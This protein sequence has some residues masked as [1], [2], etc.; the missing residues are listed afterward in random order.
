MAFEASQSPIQGDAMPPSYSAVADEHSGIDI[1]ETI[2][3]T[4][5]RELKSP[6]GESSPD[7]VRRLHNFLLY[8][9]AVDYM[10]EIAVSLSAEDQLHFLQVADCLGS[11]SQSTK[12]V[13]PTEQ[14]RQVLGPFFW[15]HLH[16]PARALGI[17]SDIV[18]LAIWRFRQ[19]RDVTGRYRGSVGMIRHNSGLRHL[20]IKLFTDK[21]F[22]VGQVARNLKEAETLI[23]ALNDVQ[24][25]FFESLDFGAAVELQPKQGLDEW[26]HAH[27]ESYTLTK[28]GRY[29]QAQQ[30]QGTKRKPV[31]QMVKSCLQSLKQL[32]SLERFNELLG[33][34]RITPAPK[35]TPAGEGDGFS[36][37]SCFNPDFWVGG[38]EGEYFAPIV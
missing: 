28:E 24:E 3:S 11:L 8:T 20:A 15:T 16:K 17:S 5:S 14:D 30:E 25:E 12:V 33:R 29:Y 21:N 35:V 31:L 34:P 2:S 1:L 7:E 27:F 10:A 19:Y 38:K 37:A 4:M 13:N 6:L 32:A 18:I 23:H 26:C 22:M 36:A 9:L